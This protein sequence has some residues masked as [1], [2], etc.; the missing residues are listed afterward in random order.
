MAHL[1]GDGV[2]YATV[3]ELRLDDDGNEE[4]AT[5]ETPAAAQI[6][7]K[8]DKKGKKQLEKERKEKEKKEK[9]LLK[10]QERQIKQEAKLKK[11][12]SLHKTASTRAS[13]NSKTA[14]SPQK[15][16]ARPKNAVACRVRMLDGSD[17][18]FDIK[19]SGVEVFFCLTCL[20]LCRI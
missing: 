8:D 17:Y 18:E 1:Q 11:S 6:S 10:E 3:D 15:T 14:A 12:P 7:V 13:K 5:N 16:E 9:Q 19:V 20:T 2:Q 4:G